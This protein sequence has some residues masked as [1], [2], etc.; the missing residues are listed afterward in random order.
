MT[1]P[2]AIG[3]ARM[4][5][6]TPSSL[7]VLSLGAGVQ[8]TTLALM[9]AAGELE[10][11]DAAIFADTQAEPA[12]VYRH[13]EWLTQPGLL[14]FP[15]YVVSR[16]NLEADFIATL[17]GATTRCGQPPFFVRNPD[18]DGIAGLDHRRMLR[19][20]ETPDKGGMLWRKCTQEYKLEVIRRK[21]REL[22]GGEPVE[23]WLGISTDEAHRMKDSG[24]RYIT[25]R[26]PL[27][28][29]RMDRGNC[30]SWL[31]KRG[32]RQPPK[33]ACYFCPYTSN[34]RWMAMKRDEPAEWEKAC[35]FDEALR[36]RRTAKLAAGIKGEI[37]VHRSMTPLRTA[38]LGDEDTLD[39]FGNE[40]EGY[41]G[42]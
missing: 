38:D 7:R 30:R 22:S 24:V 28:E 26:Y 16:G 39:L 41:C 3:K 32:Y 14:P 9:S 8:S 12:A 11:L 36:E 18:N 33:S 10:P 13:L 5:A 2:Q 35:Q 1:R 25:N 31:F 23:Q 20:E 15:V 19:P 29:R 6:D 4:S 34:E 21:V 42:V 40:C 37:F 27:I 17:S